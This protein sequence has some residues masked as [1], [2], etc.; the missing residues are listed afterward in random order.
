MKGKIYE[1]E[2]CWRLLNVGQCKRGAMTKD[3]VSKSGIRLSIATS[4]DDR[5]ELQM[6]VT[7]L[8]AYEELDL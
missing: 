5:F 4:Y 1:S 8:V 3:P 7:S 6:I 2:K